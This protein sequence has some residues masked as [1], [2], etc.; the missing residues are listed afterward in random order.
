MI[1]T[2]YKI[3]TRDGQTVAGRVQGNGGMLGGDSSRKALGGLNELRQ[4]ASGEYP[5]GGYEPKPGHVRVYP[6]FSANGNGPSVDVPIVGA[7]VEIVG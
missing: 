4:A 6:E 3:T 2:I 7:T 1:G 5:F